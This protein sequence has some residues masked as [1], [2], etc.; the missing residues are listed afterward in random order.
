FSINDKWIIPWVETIQF[1]R[2]TCAHT[3][4]IY[5]RRFNYNPHISDSI[6][7]N[8]QPSYDEDALEQLKHTLFAALCVIK[9]FYRTFPQ[10]EQNTWNNF[11]DNLNTR[12]INSNINLYYMGFPDNWLELLIIND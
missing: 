7:Q 8:I 10:N 12:I 6:E 1:L 3:A 5:G 2:N 9:E 4:R 11:L